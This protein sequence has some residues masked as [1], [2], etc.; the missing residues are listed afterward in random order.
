MLLEPSMQSANQVLPP[1]YRVQVQS[2][3]RE[4]QGDETCLLDCLTNMQSPL[5]AVP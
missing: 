5:G 3:L 4:V 1:L 2:E